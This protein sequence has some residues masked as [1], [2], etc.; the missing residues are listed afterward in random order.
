MATTSISNG[1]TKDSQISRKSKKLWLWGCVTGLILL[2][3][4]LCI[5]AYLVVSPSTLNG[6]I[7]VPPVV[8][9]GDEF[10]IIIFLTNSTG[11]SVFI[12]DITF[13]NYIGASN[14]LKGASVISTDPDMW[15]DLS[16]FGKDLVE[17][18]YN[19]EIQP[20]ETQTFTFHMKAENMGNYMG[21]IVVY[22]PHPL[23]GERLIQTLQYFS[24]IKIEITQ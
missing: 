20:G 5:V 8:N 14:L 18:R 16:I 10:D 24:A 3:I 9:Q 4:G 21:D 12:R 22:A 6:T 2:L 17:F 7:S 13:Q 19:R 1:K 15:S 23:L 11:K